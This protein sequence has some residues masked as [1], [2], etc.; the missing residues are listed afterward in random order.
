MVSGKST[1]DRRDSDPAV[2]KFTQQQVA[3]SRAQENFEQLETLLPR[4]GHDTVHFAASAFSA[5]KTVTHGFA[6]APTAVIA[7]ENSTAFGVFFTVTTISATQFQIVGTN[8]TGAFTGDAG[9]G[10]V[11]VP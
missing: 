6:K 3:D 5:T 8:P 4:R 11:A 1:L 7:T 10:W 2:M 9:F